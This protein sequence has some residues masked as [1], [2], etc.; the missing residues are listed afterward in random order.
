MSKTHLPAISVAVV[1]DGKVVYSKGFG[2]RNKAYGF[3]ATANTLYAIG[4]VTKSFTALSIMQLV[5]EGKLNLEDPV[6]K[7]APLDLKSM[8]EPVRVWHLLTHSSGIPALAYAEAIIRYATGAGGKWIPMAT[9]DELFTFM[10][11]AEKW[12]VTKPGERWFYLNEGYLLLGYIIEKI[13]GMDYREY[14]RKHI[15]EPL[16][17]NRTFFGRE[18][19]EADKDAAVPYIITKEGEQKESGYVYSLTADGGLISNV[20]DLARYIT[21]YLNRGEYNGN[22]ILPS[23]LIEEMEKPRIKLPIQVFGG[24]AYGY[25]LMTVPNFLGY[26]LVGHGGSVLTATAYM[27]YVPERKIG[28]ALLANGSGYPL[29]QLG[30]YGLALMLGRNPE[31]LPF[32]KMEKQLEALTGRYETYKGTMDAQVVKKGSFLCIVI[33]DKY[34]EEVIPLFPENLEGSV[35]TFYTLQGSGKLKVEFIVDGKDVD[36]IYERYRLKRVGS[37]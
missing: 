19:L 4:S 37:L 22:R 2:L 20:M 21:M 8:G 32:I 17:M 26:R 3:R 33:K 5:N 12:A 24:E 16:G 13:S 36:L 31:E 1:E 6:G 15:L 7:Y 18:K 28:I 10:R 11:E 27:G 34:M 23:E 29:S 30:M 35:K 25:G 9:Y 14:V